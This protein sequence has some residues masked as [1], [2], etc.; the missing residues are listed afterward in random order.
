MFWTCL[1]PEMT[2]QEISQVDLTAETVT[3]W[4]GESS[5]FNN[6]VVPG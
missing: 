5:N 1:A 4:T 3:A 2:L 6:R